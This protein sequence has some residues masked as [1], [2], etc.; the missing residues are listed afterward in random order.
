M[1]SGTARFW[2]K[3][4]KQAQK[5]QIGSE[6]GLF[7]FGAVVD[8][9]GELVGFKIGGAGDVEEFV[10]G[11][12]VEVAG[13]AA[14]HVEVFVEFFAVN[15]ACVGFVLFGDFSLAVFEHFVGGF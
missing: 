6:S 11:R 7:E 10:L 15:C 5:K 12:A 1:E 2:R 14:E 4:K 13:R 3:S 8:E 9:K